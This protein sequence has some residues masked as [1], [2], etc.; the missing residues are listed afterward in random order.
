MEA[1]DTFY[2]FS[3]GFADS[4]NGATGKKLTT[5]KFKELLLSNRQVPVEEQ[6]ATLEQFL[7]KWSSGAEQVD[8]ILVIGIRM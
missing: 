1:G 7:E 5:K 8:D 2:I 4:F 6:G 3:D